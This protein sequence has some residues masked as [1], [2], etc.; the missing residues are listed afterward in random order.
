MKKWSNTVI[1]Y[2]LCIQWEKFIGCT[3]EIW[4]ADVRV[5]KARVYVCLE[6]GEGVNSVL[7]VVEAG[8]IRLQTIQTAGA[9]GQKGTC[10]YLQPANHHWIRK[11]QDL[12]P[13]TRS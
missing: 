6:F 1:V 2:V 8:K 9:Q 12:Q 5:E 13:P 4:Q 11:D 3:G 7:K 10:L